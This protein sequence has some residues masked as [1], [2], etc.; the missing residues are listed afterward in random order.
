MRLKVKEPKRVIK[1]KKL[2]NLKLGLINFSLI[3][4]KMVIPK[5]KI[6]PAIPALDKIITL[7]IKYT[8][9]PNKIIIPISGDRVQLYLPISFQV[10]DAFQYDNAAL[11]ADPEEPKQVVTIGNTGTVFEDPSGTD[12]KEPDGIYGNSSLKS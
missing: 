5:E 10:N 1:I 11:G 8:K 12:S 7:A 3:P 9:K 6:A 2:A 4:I